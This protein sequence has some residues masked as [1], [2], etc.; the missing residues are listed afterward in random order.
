MI[1]LKKTDL[2]DGLTI[3]SDNDYRSG[4]IFKILLHD[5]YHKCY[6]CEQKPIPP[7]VEHR[8]THK[9][10]EA[11]KYDWYNIFYSCRYCNKVKNQKKFYDGI[12]DPTKIDPED[13][14]ELRLDYN[15]TPF[16][17]FLITT[18]KPAAAPVPPPVEPE[19]D[20]ETLLNENLPVREKLTA[21]RA[22]QLKK[23]Y[24]VKPVDFTE[25]QTRK[26]YIDVMLEDAGWQ[27]RVG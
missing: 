7:E 17:K 18:S 25:D 24:T 1:K 15:E 12:I 10:D 26:A 9:G 19:V 14:I 13:Y 4:E 6:I 5:C 16:N 8:L 11:L 3:T 27:R 21:R 23:G 2:P 20:F 22:H